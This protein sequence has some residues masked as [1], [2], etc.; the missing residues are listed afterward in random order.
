MARMVF[1]LSLIRPEVESL[2]RHWGEQGQA[3]GFPV[4]I[5]T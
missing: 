3:W 2:W 5:W 1:N 4:D